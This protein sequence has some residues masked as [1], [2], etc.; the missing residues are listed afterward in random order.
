MATLYDTKIELNGVEYGIAAIDVGNSRVKIHHDDVF[1]SFPYDKEWKKNVQHHFRDHVSKRYLIGLSS[2]NPKQTTAIVKVLQR[3][4][5][6]LV[7]NAH[8]LLMRNESALSLGKVENA[9][10]DRMLGTIGAMT[11]AEPPVITVD[12]GTAVTVNA[13]D[14]DH[15]F[16]GG[17][18]FAG[19]STQL[20]GLA[21]QTAAIPEMKYTPPTTHIGVNTIQ[22]LMAGI[23]A[24]VVG[25]VQ[26]SVDAFIAKTF[27]KKSA[28]VIV[29]GGESQQ[30]VE[31]L[32]DRGYTVIYHQHM[33]TDGILVLL[34]GAKNVDLQDA[35]IG[36]ILS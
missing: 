7:L 16:L 17:V 5:G 18:V 36:K 28:P 29:S 9:G 14:K 23:T 13:V 30:V 6:H 10:I 32:S 24:S 15:H 2:V 19:I 31:A 1:L 22:C 34:A 20:F 12:C 25:G 33:V 26:Q 3:I 11:K 35:I 21:K 27:D 4:P 8:Q